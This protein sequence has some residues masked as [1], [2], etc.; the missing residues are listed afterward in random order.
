M[1]ERSNGKYTHY[2]NDGT[3]WA[4]G[5]MNGKK[6]EGMWKWFRKD[7]TLMRS[8]RFR[9]GKQTGKWTTYD[10]KCK[11]VKVTDMDKKLKKKYS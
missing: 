6:M 2:H 5:R 10:S 3:I 4:I 1:K 7:G 9:G 11:I 8:G